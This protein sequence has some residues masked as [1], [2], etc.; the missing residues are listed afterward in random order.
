MRYLEWLWLLTLS[1]L[2]TVLANYIGHGVP[3]RESVPGVVVMVAISMLAVVCVKYIPFKLPIV[4][5]CA[6]IG[7]ITASPISPIREF[8]ILATDKISFTAPFTIVGAYA[9]MAISD[10]VQT[11]IKQG[12]KILLIGLLVITSVFLGLCIWDTLLL[13]ISGMI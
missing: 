10:Q 3:I 6:V 13:K 9:G 4:A 11:F 1:A 5:Y 8:V 7:L 12:P 2:G